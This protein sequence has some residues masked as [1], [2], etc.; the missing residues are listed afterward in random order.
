MA[1]DNI[2][3]IIGEKAFSEVER[4]TDMLEQLGTTF[5]QTATKV[6][7]IE[8]KLTA[9]AEMKELLSMLEKTKG[10]SKELTQ[11]TNTYNKALESKAKI[12]RL[13]AESSA[14]IAN[15]QILNEQKVRTEVER[16][17]AAKA[18]A[19]KAEAA[20]IEADKK[21]LELENKRAE[22]KAK[23]R[24]A[25][26]AEI[27]A[28]YAQVK[29]LQDEYNER[30]RLASVADNEATKQYHTAKATEAHIKTK[31][32][33]SNANK[34]ARRSV[35]L[36]IV[37][38]RAAEAQVKSLTKAEAA[39][40]AQLAKSQNEYEA[41]K[42][43][44]NE[45]ANQAKVLGT[46]YL[47]LAASGKA[48]DAQLT[49]ASKRW[50]DAK[51]AANGYLDTLRTVEM[52]VGQHQRNVGNYNALLVETNQILR[53][54]PNFAISFRTGIL[55][56]SNNL[57]MFFDAFKRASQAIDQATNRVA[58]FRG[59]MKTLGGAILSWQ[60]ILIVA[61]TLLVQ[62]NEQILDF[63][64]NLSIGEKI[65]R[66]YRKALKE[67]VQEQ[68]K[69]IGQLMVLQ[70]V[71][72]DTNKSVAEQEKAI[73]EAQKS[74]EGYF[75]TISTGNPDLDQT[76]KL[77]EDMIALRI[78]AAQQAAADKTVEE[79][80]QNLIIAQQ[81][82]NEEVTFWQ[83]LWAFVKD[84]YGSWF[85]MTKEGSLEQQVLAG[86]INDV[87]EAQEG[88]TEAVELSINPRQKEIDKLEEQKAVQEELIKE[89][90]KENRITAKYG[91]GWL[92]TATINARQKDIDK[93][94]E[95]ITNLNEL[96]A[97]KKE[98]IE[99]DR[100]RAI[101]ATRIMSVNDRITIE[102][103]NQRQVLKEGT[104]ERIKADRAWADHRKE[105]V[106]EAL[107]KRF[108]VNTEEEL[109][110]ATGE[111]TEAYKQYRAEL[112]REY[113]A[114]ENSIK[115]KEK[116]TKSQKQEIDWT[117]RIADERNKM[118][119]AESEGIQANMNITIASNKAILEDET[120]TLEKRLEAWSNWQNEQFR[121]ISE[122]DRL[123][124]EQLNNSISAIDTRLNN[125][126]KL[127]AGE[128]EFLL[129]QKETLN[130][131][132][133]N[134]TNKQKDKQNKLLIESN[135]S[136]NGILKSD[137]Q[138][139]LSIAE[140]GFRDELLTIK[141]QTTLKLIELDR[142]RKEG[143]V[144]ERRYWRERR[145]I[146][147]EENNEILRKQAEYLEQQIKTQKELLAS[148]TSPEEKAAIQQ[149]I[150]L[151]E[152]LYG[153]LIRGR[154]ALELT[155]G[156]EVLSKI[157][158]S[159]TKNSKASAEEIIE[160]WNQV[161]QVLQKSFSSIFENIQKMRENATQKRLDEL[162][163]EN[164]RLDKIYQ[165]E[166]NRVNSSLMTEQ[167]KQKQIELLN[168]RKL[169]DEQTLE[170]ERIKI[171]REAAI[172]NQNIEMANA[173]INGAAAAVKVLKDVQYPLSMVA[174]AAILAQVGT[175][176]ATIRSTP[177][178][179][180]WQGTDDHKGGL[181]YVGERGTELVNLPSGQSFLTPNK[182]TLLDL[183]KGTEVISHHELARLAQRDAVLAMSA[184]KSV[185]ENDYAA[186]FLQGFENAMNMGSHKIVN[187]INNKQE[188]HFH[189]SNGELRKSIKRNG[190][191]INYLKG[192]I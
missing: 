172:R 126:K 2:N 192:I 73:R 92:P 163:K 76:N 150:N 103:D 95:T 144:T 39:E 58:G 64:Q 4:L 110:A 78:M 70:T 98:E 161:A 140:Q 91:S 18:N 107:L 187:A 12:E 122:V 158:S 164:E 167:E 151:L 119:K 127:S 132:L 66:S 178:P 149:T 166:E 32:T 104:A 133:N 43:K 155:F 131:Q 80:T 108:S 136:Y 145:A 175:Q 55:S 165:D 62:Y 111:T 11:L 44:Y 123:E 83:K 77:I 94:K 171:E 112:E 24:V 157:F 188:T 152:Q 168:A 37:A 81:K 9:N 46:Q 48:N 59:A 129:A 153:T 42:V 170:K 109:L 116:R 189:W 182:T 88:L 17:N 85:G 174:L 128:R 34:S 13:N 99:L 101:S 118:L 115:V 51:N 23:N 190:S 135:K 154:K 148:A 106:K 5:S 160:D 25:T 67:T 53:E 147:D 159:L 79:A 68:A 72:N 96:I 113:I 177:I 121:L 14:K 21:A 20:K 40:A 47:N 137:L 57:P 84:F 97:D 179:G 146:M 71:L 141:K 162:D 22:A 1:L 120:Q 185:G 176:I 54:V 139:R 87:K 60:T 142:G 45:A 61:V 49:A 114:I 191:M 86:R 8:I 186:A 93:I 15:Q 130:T 27:Q 69:E 31:E 28:L 19:A 3:S 105:A 52:T 38:E 90:E 156:G 56:L 173:V 65:Q 36:M 35:E 134:L 143:T 181:A 50:Q 16:T 75:D 26:E 7:E 184:K 74:F 169:V 100:Q 29:A 183:P 41:L 10:L 138:T 33:L 63:I 117:K 89:K 30:L 180:Y 82:L 124:L 6:K 102:L 125:A